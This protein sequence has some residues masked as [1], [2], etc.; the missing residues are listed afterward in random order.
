[1]ICFFFIS[2]FSYRK[3]RFQTDSYSWIEH[4]IWQSADGRTKNE[5]VVEMHIN[6]QPFSNKLKVFASNT[7]ASN[8]F[9]CRDFDGKKDKR[10][11]CKQMKRNNEIDLFFFLCSFFGNNKNRFQSMQCSVIIENNQLLNIHLMVS[12]LLLLVHLSTHSLLRFSLTVYFQRIIDIAMVSRE[13]VSLLAIFGN[14]MRV[15]SCR[16]RINDVTN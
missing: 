4:W 12:S 9:N 2:V 5:Y 1:M 6:G 7:N 8:Q 3:R 13:R 11:E 14:E 16:K 10:S 15:M